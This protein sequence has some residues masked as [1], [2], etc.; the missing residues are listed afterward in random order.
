MN[1]TFTQ[2]GYVAVLAVALLLAQMAFAPM[3]FAASDYASSL[4]SS[5]LGTQKDGDPVG[6]GRDDA[7]EALGA[8]DDAFVSLGYGGEVVLGFPLSMSGN[9]SVTVFETTNPPHPLEEAEIAVASDPAGPWT[10]VGTAD[11]TGDSEF[12]VD[13]CFQYV[14]VVDTTDGDIHGDDSDGFDLDAIEATYDEECAPAEEEEEDEGGDS[15]DV[16]ISVRNTAM[17]FNSTQSLANTGGNYAGGSTGGSGGTGGGIASNGADQDIEGATTGSG[18]AGGNG[19]DGGLVTTGEASSH[20]YT[21][22]V[23][24][25]TDVIVNRCA[26]EG[27]D[28]GNVRIATRSTTILANDTSSAANSG[29]NMAR[30]SRGGEGGDGGNIGANGGEDDGEGQEL[31]DVATGNGG[32]G[33]TGGI[34]GTVQTSAASSTATTENITDRTRVRVAR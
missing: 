11:N 15:G 17:I 28:S 13:Q 21:R 2:V 32:T 10:I 19:S 29:L 20:S 34:G 23:V 33:G 31:D 3:A 7:T 24:N 26:C 27:D 16:R 8:P 18:G 12:T 25:T 6:P 14:R 5:S 30:G 9:L 1:S 4:E 22:N